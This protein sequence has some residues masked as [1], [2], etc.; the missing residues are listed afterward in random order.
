MAAILNWCKSAIYY[1]HVHTRYWNFKPDYFDTS[2]V[3]LSSYLPK[4]QYIL[5]SCDHGIMWWLANKMAAIF[6]LCEVDYCHCHIH[7]RFWNLNPDYFDTL[8]MFLSSFCS[9]VMMHNVII[10]Q[11]HGGYLGF[12]QMRPLS[13]S[14]YIVANSI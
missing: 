1:Y 12:M 5:W 13:S 6:N 10:C 3:F 4:L 8:Y 14:L 7:T 2:H 9:K 11:S